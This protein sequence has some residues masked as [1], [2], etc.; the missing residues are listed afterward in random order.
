MFYCGKRKTYQYNIKW[1]PFQTHYYYELLNRAAGLHLEM[2]ELGYVRKSG[3]V[4]WATLIS[5][6]SKLDYKWRVRNME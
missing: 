4:F 5:D 1:I 3:T 2:P 6:L